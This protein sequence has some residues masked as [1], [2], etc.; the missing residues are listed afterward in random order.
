MEK[1]NEINKRNKKI[2][3]LPAELRKLYD[4]SMC[5]NQKL[6]MRLARL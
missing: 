2:D 5:H 1:E 3:T 4:D 6:M